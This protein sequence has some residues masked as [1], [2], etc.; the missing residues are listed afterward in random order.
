MS[1][2][3]NVV[4]M[5][6]S[7]IAHNQDRLPRTLHGMHANGPGIVDIIQYEHLE[8]E[9][10]GIANLIRDLTTRQGVSPGDILVL[11]QRRVIGTPIFNALRQFGVPV[12]SFYQESELDNAAAQE[13]L[14]ILK[15]L[16]NRDD[17]VAMRWLL[18]LG[19]NNFRANAYG[20]LRQY[21]GRTGLSPWRAL[22]SLTAGEI[23]IAHI[24]SLIDRFREIQYEIEALEQFEDPQEFIS[25]WLP[26][27][28]FEVAQLRDVAL[29]AMESARTRG[30]LLDAIVEEITQPEIPLEVTEVRIMSLHRSKGLSSPVV[31]IAGCVEGLLPK[32]PDAGLSTAEIRAVI[33]EERRLFFV[34]LT[35]VKS[36][37]SYDKPG[38]LYLTYSRIW[39]QADALG[40]GSA[41]T[42]IR[43][44]SAYFN[45]SRFLAELGSAA[46][47]PRAG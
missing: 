40:S 22:V 31:I 21:C 37:P 16:V 4:Q 13:R 18:G 19:G 36:Q 20:R 15:L 5:A 38:M 46:P 29:S 33:E 1:C 45:A 41:P 6:N 43:R 10:S 11:A 2:P 9:V 34:G 30:D 42:H 24:G 17:K 26:D 3:T 47:Q 35:R 28:T 27:D 23:T 14:S 7:L 8:Q 32:R 25:Q 12:K 39:S 44:G